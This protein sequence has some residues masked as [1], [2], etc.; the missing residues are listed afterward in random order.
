MSR[1]QLAETATNFLNWIN[2]P[3]LDPAV[4]ATIVSKDVKIP[5]PYPGAAP[6]YDG[7]LAIA[8]AA[9]AA[10]EGFHMTLKNMVIDEEASTVV[11]LINITG[12]HVGYSR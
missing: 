2:S 8:N 1:A 11:L 4:L 10:A 6:T 9:H 3:E 12:K 5:I 7:L